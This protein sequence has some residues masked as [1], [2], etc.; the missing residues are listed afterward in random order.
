[1]DFKAFVGRFGGSLRT[2]NL[3]SPVDTSWKKTMANRRTHYLGHRT[4]LPKEFIRQD[5]WEAE[6]LYLIAARAKLAIVETGRWNGGSALMMAC[7]NPD[8]P[9]HSIDIAPQDDGALKSLLAELGVGAN[10]E[11][12]VGDSQN[13]KYPQIAAF[14]LLFIDGDHSY[15]GCTK[16]IENWWP[17]M[18][19][20]GHMVLHDCYD[21]CAVMDACIDFLDRHD[22]IVHISPFRHNN[23][24]TH[25]AGSMV[26]FQKRRR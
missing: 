13:C 12:I 26:H 8:I 11:L 17:D 2:K 10:I 15:E 9:I 1:M 5:P 24:S 18:A 7:A 14:D 22:P 3:N 4:E 23:H 19:P 21:G 25:P 6:Y 20:G 16:D